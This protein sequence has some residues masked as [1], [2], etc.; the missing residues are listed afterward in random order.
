[1]KCRIPASMKQWPAGLA[2]SETPNERLL[3]RGL[4]RFCGTTTG[5]GTC[6]GSVIP[7]CDGEAFQINK[8]APC[9]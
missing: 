1:M 8:T 7:R 6:D 3:Q 5:T 4:A 2:E 9:P